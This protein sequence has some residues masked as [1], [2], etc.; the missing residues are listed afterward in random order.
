MLLLKLTCCLQNKVKFNSVY[1]GFEK[2][3]GTTV[4]IN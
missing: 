1:L 4:E 2:D 3:N